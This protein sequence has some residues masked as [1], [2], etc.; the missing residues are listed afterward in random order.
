MEFGYHI[1]NKIIHKP[2]R[3][4]EKY[5]IIYLDYLFLIVSL[6]PCLFQGHTVDS[7]HKDKFQ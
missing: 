4:K 5:F 1:L 2:K 7:H 6:I 3:H